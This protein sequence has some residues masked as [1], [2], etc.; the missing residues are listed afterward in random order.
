[1]LKKYSPY[2][3]K[4]VYVALPTTYSPPCLI[5]LEGTIPV[6]ASPKPVIATQLHTINSRNRTSVH[7]LPLFNTEKSSPESVVRFS[8]FLLS[9]W[10]GTFL[11]GNSS[12]IS[13][14]SVVLSLNIGRTIA[15]DCSL[16]LT[17][18]LLT[19]Q[20]LSLTHRITPLTHDLF[21]K[22]NRQ[23]YWKSKN[24]IASPACKSSISVNSNTLLQICTLI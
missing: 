6:A 19:E 20:L 4:Y 10:S 22:T 7:L 14:D 24:S 8:N 11:S 23:N 21:L 18:Q 13:P 16:L 15:W 1:M 9:G 2:K 5:C 12:S 17:E 3:W